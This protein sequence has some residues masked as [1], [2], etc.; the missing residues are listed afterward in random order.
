MPLAPDSDELQPAQHG[1]VDFVGTLETGYVTTVVDHNEFGAG[2]E[3]CH[4]LV[5]N[6]WREFI[7]T[8]AQDQAWNTHPSEVSTAA[9]RSRV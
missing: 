6:K 4:F 9:P 8:A 5:I 7:F 3:A 2:N 1:R